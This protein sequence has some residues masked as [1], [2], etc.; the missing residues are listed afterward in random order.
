MPQIISM[1]LFHAFLQ[2]FCKLHVALVISLITIS[3]NILSPSLCIYLMATCHFRHKEMISIILKSNFTR[4]MVQKL[5]Y[6]KIYNVHKNVKNIW[7]YSILSHLRILLWIKFQCS[8][9]KAP[10][11]KGVSLIAIENS[12]ASASNK[13]I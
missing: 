11:K 4:H 1:I 6:W 12:F 10:Q 8:L 7:V 9:T 5:V 3:F 13:M 2:V